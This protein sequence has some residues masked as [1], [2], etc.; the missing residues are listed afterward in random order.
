MGGCII[1]IGAAEESEGFPAMIVGR[2]LRGR[3]DILEG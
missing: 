3:A 1:K 2:D